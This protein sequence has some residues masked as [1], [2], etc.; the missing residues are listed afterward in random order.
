MWESDVIITV[1]AV[2]DAIAFQFA[3]PPARLPAP[4]PQVFLLRD[5]AILNTTTTIPPAEIAYIQ[6]NRIF[7]RPILNTLSPFPLAIAMCR[8]RSLAFVT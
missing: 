5:G 8:M 6:K 1:A 7:V 3:M 4:K 2:V